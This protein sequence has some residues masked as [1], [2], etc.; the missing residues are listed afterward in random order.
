MPYSVPPPAPPAVVSFI[1][2]EAL[3]HSVPARPDVAIALPS[4]V[5]RSRLPLSASGQVSQAE[6]YAAAPT[7]PASAAELGA[8]LEGYTSSDDLVGQMVQLP[9]VEALMQVQ[10]PASTIQRLPVLEPARPSANWT[11]LE[12][13][14]VLPAPTSPDAPASTSPIEPP[15]LETPDSV[16]ELPADPEAPVPETAAPPPSP[17]T[18]DPSTGSPDITITAPPGTGGIV[19]LDAD[20]QEYD[21]LRDIFTGE[22]NVEMRFRGAVLTADRVQVNLINRIAV[23]EGNAQLVQGEQILRGNRFEYNFVQTQGTILR[24]SGEVFLP[25]LGDSFSSTLAT[26]A[27]AGAVQPDSGVSSLG[28]LSIG[29]GNSGGSPSGGAIRRFRFEAD[30]LDFTAGGWVATNVRITN[31]PFSPPE[32]ELR[33]NTA[34]FTRLSPTRSEIRARNPRLVFDQGF[35]LPLLRNRLIL[36]D[37]ERNTLFQLGFDDEDRGGLFVESTFSLISSPVVQLQV[38]PQVF[39]QR[40]FTDSPSLFEP[41]N[42]G[43]ASVLNI[44]LSP[45]TTVEGNVVLTSLDT[46]DLED[47]LR[48]SLRAKQLL[49]RYTLALE[50][51]YRDRLFNGSL[52]YQNV[53]NSL[54]FIVTSPQIALG[55]TGINLSYQAGVQAVTANTD[56]LDLLDSVRTNDRIDLTRYQASVALNRPIVL[57]QGQ[58]LPATPTEGLRYTPN[59][60]APYLLLIPSARAVVGLYSNGD[61]QSTFTGSLG[62]YGQFGHFSRP[63]LDYTS[64][65]LTYSQS[66]RQGESPFLFDRDVDQQVLS[67]GFLQQIYGPLRLGVQASINLDRN[68]SIDTDYILEYS[69]RA[70]AITLRYNPERQVGSLGLRISDF[71][72]GTAPEPFSGSGGTVSGGVRQSE[73]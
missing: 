38:R 66:A 64:F 58:P 30:Q 45:T 15:A 9:E 44:T 14:S 54:G 29:L 31:D 57:W 32:L 50:Y 24:A 2:P 21:V 73:D 26:D 10:R 59:P 28:G 46:A 33:A 16:L 56:R 3:T 18:A 67:A 70:Y 48:A 25:T 68:Q 4:P 13:E 43:V 17:P 36:D 71:N 34:T 49:G 72:W 37:R 19:E 20:R 6:L 5:F 39:L 41:R 55:N 69:R 63:F 12:Q 52:G 22:G 40:A 65:N 62:L 7:E 60:I 35:T 11:A 53:Q 47:N 27:S 51:S 8:P 61:S 42:F 1:Q 23:A